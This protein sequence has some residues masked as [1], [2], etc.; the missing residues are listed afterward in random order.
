MKSKVIQVTWDD[1]E[2]TD[3]EEYDDSN[4]FI[5]FTILIGSANSFYEYVLE[6]ID[7]D[8]VYELNNNE[9]SRRHIRN[10]LKFRLP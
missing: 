4:N 10:C 6:N 7:M 9:V 8:E 2:N 3:D 5:S 1:L